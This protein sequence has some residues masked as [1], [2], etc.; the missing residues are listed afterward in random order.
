[1][2]I[3]GKIVQRIKPIEPTKPYIDAEFAIDESAIYKRLKLTPYNPDQLVSR[4]GIKIFE[5]MMKDEEIASCI[6]AL[7]IMRLSSGWEIVAASDEEKDR[8]IAEFVEWNLKNIEGSFEADLFEIMGALEYGISIS[9]KVFGIVKKGKWKDK[10]YLKALKS[11]N[12]KYFNIWTDDFDNIL[13]NGVVNISSVDYGK[14]YPVEKFVIYT[15]RKQFENVFGVSRI[16]VLYDLWYLKQLWTRAWGIYLE[17][18]GHPVPVGKYPRGYDKELREKIFEAIK[19]IK[20]ETA[21]MIPNDVEIDFITTQDKSAPFKEAIEYVNSQIRKVILGQTLTTDTR[22]VGSYSLGRVH[23][24]IL[25]MYLEQL[26]KDVASKAI[27]QQVVRYIVDYNFNDVEDYPE[28]RFKPLVQ[29]DIE[30]MIDKYYEGVKNG[31]IKPISEDEERLREWLGLPKR[32]VK[33]NEVLEINQTTEKFEE[34]VDHKG[35]IFTG[36]DRRRFTKYEEVVDFAEIKYTI[37]NI[38]EKINEKVAGYIQESVQEMIRQVDKLKILENKNLDDIDKIKFVNTGEIRDVIKDNLTRVFESGISIARREVMNKKSK[39]GYSEVVKF[40]FDID[41][42][43]M[44]PE[45]VIKWIDTHAYDLAGDIKDYFIGEFRDILKN[46][47]LRGDNLKSVVSA[48]EK[49]VSRYVESGVIDVP[50]SGYRL[51]ALVRTNINMAFNMG[52][53]QFFEDPQLGG[54]VVGYQ[55]SAILDP[56]TTRVCQWLDGKTFSVTYKDLEV[57]TPPNHWNCRSILVP[58]TQMD[59]IE[60]FDNRLPPKDL[61]DVIHNFKKI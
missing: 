21:I 49:V 38:T 50:V 8:E 45:E 3:L 58:I 7:K 46:A 27:N 40:Q 20:L 41:L 36:V 52:R 39:R 47:I 6:E 30:K 34:V 55:Y 29:Q 57:I 25:M 44:K 53:R 51:E 2:S 35:K 33:E 9:E 16:R 42:R 13:E 18:F 19:S 15:F 43:A 5:E 11:K 28:F 14:Q 12:P 26:G 22:G 54:F 31:V 60:E 61:L 17:K 59:E 24:D 37:E 48:L 56:R 32:K 1:M 4:K 23:F 10:I